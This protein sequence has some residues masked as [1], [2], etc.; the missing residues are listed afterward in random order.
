MSNEYHCCTHN[1]DVPPYLRCPDMRSK[2]PSVNVYLDSDEIEKRLDA[3]DESQAKQDTTLEKATSDIEALE[4]SVAA[5][6]ADQKEQNESLYKHGDRIADLESVIKHDVLPYIGDDDDRDD[7][8]EERIAALEAAKAE[9]DDTLAALKDG[10]DA[11]DADL[12]GIHDELSGVH[13]EITALGVVDKAQNEQITRLNDYVEAH[14]KEYEADHLALTLLD[15]AHTSDVRSLVEDITEL[16]DADSELKAKDAEQDGRLGDL[17]NDLANHISSAAKDREELVSS[18]VE[19]FRLAEEAVNRNSDD[20]A[21][22]KAGVQSVQNTQSSIT[23]TVVVDGKEKAVVPYSSL[24]YAN[25]KDGNPVMFSSSWQ[26]YQK[27]VSDNRNLILTL[28]QHD[29]DKA[30]DLRTIEAEQTE[31]NSRLDSLEQSSHYDETINTRVGV[32]ETATVD[33][34]ANLEAIQSVLE[35][36]ETRIAELESKVSNLEALFAADS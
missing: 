5:I 27:I 31:Q 14:K 4:K 36:Y 26:Q 13:D 22:L 16:Q 30:T 19:Q 29:T 12:T 28:Q 17:E 18:L 8:Q 3:L 15:E 33:A 10:H 20:I 9:H 7:K 35:A 25:D 21:E 6:E 1:P 24:Y 32:L 11:Q 23:K 2:R 34:A